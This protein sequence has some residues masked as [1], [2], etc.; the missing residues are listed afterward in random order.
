[1]QCELSVRSWPRGTSAILLRSTLPTA[2]RPIRMAPQG[3][4][5]VLYES[6]ICGSGHLGWSQGG[7]I[8]GRGWHS[9][10]SLENHDRGFEQRDEDATSDECALLDRRASE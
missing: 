6:C 4:C 7:A 2:D 3:R 1:M 10:G 9:A 5:R 8:D